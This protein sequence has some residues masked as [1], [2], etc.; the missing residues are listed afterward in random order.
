MAFFLSLPVSIDFTTHPLAINDE[1]RT[2]A[3]KVKS[4]SRRDGDGNGG[5][6]GGEVVHTTIRRFQLPLSSQLRRD[7]LLL[8]TNGKIEK[9]EDSKR[10]NE[11]ERQRL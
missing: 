6:G 10:V 3:E 1:T 4:K 11:K 9:E 2:K 7:Y 8:T 5:G